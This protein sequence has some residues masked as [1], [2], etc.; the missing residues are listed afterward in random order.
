MMNNRTGADAVFE[1]SLSDFFD[2]VARQ[3]GE[4]G[5]TI[6]RA[7][8]IGKRGAVCFSVKQQS[9]DLGQIPASSGD[10]STQHARNR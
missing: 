1:Q 8:G 5:E 9:V 4:P 7:Q 3:Y 6:L 2:G 10:Y